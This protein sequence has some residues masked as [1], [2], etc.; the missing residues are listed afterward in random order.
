MPSLAPCLSQFKQSDP[1][2]FGGLGLALLTLFRAATM[3]DW[4]DLMYTSMLGCGEYGYP[5]LDE[6]GWIPG[7]PPRN[8]TITAFCEAAPI[9]TRI[10]DAQLI[11]E[12]PTADQ[13]TLNASGSMV[14]NRA[15]FPDWDSY[16]RAA[17]D[18]AWIM[19]LGST[20]STP[21]SPPYYIFFILVAGIVM[22][23]LFIGAVTLGMQEAMDETTESKR[24]ALHEKLKSAA[25]ISQS[26]LM[27]NDSTANKVA[28]MWMG[29]ALA[30]VE[31]EQVA[32]KRNL[33][34]EAPIW[35]MLDRFIF[36]PSSFVA[37]HPL[38]TKFIT[39]V[40]I[41]AAIL[42]GFDFTQTQPIDLAKVLDCGGAC[43][44]AVTVRP[45]SAAQRNVALTQ[46][47]SVSSS[48]R[49]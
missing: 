39:G 41:L 45:L 32:E 18:H 6:T 2:H 40:I 7:I 35:Y 15:C 31:E 11:C 27:Q 25:R 24:K 28:R 43:P 4:S 29:E 44:G 23:S 21:F 10:P 20:D 47:H 12:S 34:S 49:D 9:G 3:E 1:A 37:N 22:L 36:Q 38:F 13:Q 8:D 19:W 30:D 46:F 26:T 33:Y 5:A 48:L 17:H 16:F 14:N 42:V